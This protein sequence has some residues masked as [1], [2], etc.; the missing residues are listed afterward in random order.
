MNDGVFRDPRAHAAALEEENQKLH[1]ELVRLRNEV[2]EL[3]DELEDESP[4]SADAAMRRLKVERDELRLEVKEV[5]GLRV[6]LNTEEQENLTLKKD[7]REARSEAHKIDMEL[8]AARA[9]LAALR[10]E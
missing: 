9:E 5:N 3:R 4:T 1:E 8:I 7:H 6:R 10:E 2:R